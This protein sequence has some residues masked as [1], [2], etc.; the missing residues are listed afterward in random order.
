MPG[1]RQGIDKD[2]NAGNVW[3]LEGFMLVTVRNAG[4]MVPTDKR[5]EALVMIRNFVEGKPL[6]YKS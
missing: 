3:T 4:H 5:Q 6:P 2:Q 1:I